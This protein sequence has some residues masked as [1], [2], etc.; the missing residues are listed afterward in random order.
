MVGNC[1][2]FFVGF[3]DFKWAFGTKSGRCSDL[4]ER[5]CAESGPDCKG[6]LS[7]ANIRREIGVFLSSELGKGGFCGVDMHVNVAQ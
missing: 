3:I 1:G 7:A 6:R 5:K 4:M 2:S